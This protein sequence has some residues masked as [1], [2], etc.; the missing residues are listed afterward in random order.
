MYKAALIAVAIV[1][2]ASAAAAR[3]G[4]AAHP[5]A[6]KMRRGADSLTVRGV[7]RQN[8][9]CCAYTF[10]AHAGQQLRWT[11]SGAAARMGIA[12]PDGDGINPGLP[13]PAALPQTGRYVLTVSPD[14]MAEGA[15]GRF[16]LTVRIP[17]PR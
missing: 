15:F 8:V 14:L 10:K 3:P 6:L 17:P 1:S 5:I 7:L 12:Y 11:E 13:N 9:D 16:T 4:D 2:V